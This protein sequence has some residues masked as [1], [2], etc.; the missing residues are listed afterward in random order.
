MKFKNLLIVILLMLLITYFS[1]S[2]LYESKYVV[3]I[4][5]LIIPSFC[6]F[7]CFGN[8]Q[9]FPKKYLLFVL[10]FYLGETALLFMDKIH[11]LYT[12]SMF[13]K[14]LS[15]LFLI[16]LVY[17]FVKSLNLL[18]EIK[19]HEL[20]IFSIIISILVLMLNM[21]FNFETD[22]FLNTIIVLNAILSIFLI[23]ISFLYLKET[24]NDK[25]VYFFLGTFCIFCSDVMS[26]LN[27]YY[28]E[29]FILNLSERIL[30]FLGFY[31]IYLFTINKSVKE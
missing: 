8:K 18:N 16:N 31:L 26:A 19:I 17:P 12:T 7:V 6:L 1:A 23:I 9:I 24:F 10:F 29:D 14:L 20:I 11:F 28:L 13:F 5:P 30:H 25:S 2:F 4:K 21:I 15:Y 3:F 22:F 27:F